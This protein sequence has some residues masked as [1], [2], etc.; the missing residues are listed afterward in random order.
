MKST[1]NT[2]EHIGKKEKPTA[3]PSLDDLDIRDYFA[4][5]AM[6]TAS[7]EREA[8]AK[9]ADEY[10]TYGGSNF[11]EWFKKLAAEIRARGKRQE[12]ENEHAVSLASVQP[13]VQEPVAYITGV[14]AGYFRAEPIDRSA[15]LKA[16]MA[17]YTH[18]QP[19][20]GDIRALKHRIHELEGEVLGYKQIL[21]DQENETHWLKYVQMQIEHASYVFKDS[22]SHTNQAIDYLRALLHADPFSKWKEKV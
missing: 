4:A 16:G 10:A 1:T 12:P 8:C 7:Q 17:L 13:S 19:A 5:K 3:I 9:L 6:Q 18:T 11:N 21:S 22:C 2:N 20:P 15:V 14:N